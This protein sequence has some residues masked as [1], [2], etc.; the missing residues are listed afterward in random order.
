[1]FEVS[2]LMAISKTTLS[3]LRSLMVSAGCFTWPCSLQA[4]QAV[5]APQPNPTVSRFVTTADSLRLPVAILPSTTL[6]KWPVLTE[7]QARA[8]VDRGR[9]V[10]R[11]GD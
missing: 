6:A 5:P 4:Q 7:A 11:K 10:A 2:F 8:D 9:I 3:I 1:M